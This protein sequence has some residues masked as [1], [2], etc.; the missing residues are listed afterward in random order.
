MN[1]AFEA[2]PFAA[3]AREG[4]MEQNIHDGMAGE[5]EE[6]RGRMSVMRGGGGGRGGG[7]RGM[8]NRTGLPVHRGGARPG[9]GP[10]GRPAPAGGG[11]PSGRR[12]A[13][14]SPRPS[15]WPRGPYW[16]PVYGWPRDVMVSEPGGYPWP[17]EDAPPAIEPL[18][19]PPQDDGNGGENQ[20]IPPE[21]LTTLGALAMPGKPVYR[22]L[23]SLMRAPGL[24]KPKVAGFYLIVFPAGGRPPGRLRAYSGQT[25]DLKRRMLEHIVEINR[26]GLHAPRHKVFIA[27]STLGDEARR[28]IEYALHD[29]MLRDHFG[30]LTNPR[31]ELAA[32]AWQ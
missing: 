15:R 29:R 28:A 19:F 27:E 13:R 9:R 24:L 18:D 23:G 11:L 21:L 14:P 25:D 4:D 2:L 3:G 7:S 16:G 5:L 6:E 17:V 1:E 20:E 31:R 10:V 12:G 30:V 8:V 26:L 22:L 32:Q